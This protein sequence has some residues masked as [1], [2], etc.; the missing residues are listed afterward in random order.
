M[1]NMAE[2]VLIRHGQTTWSKA[3][4]HTSVTDLPL[5]ES[6]EKQ[7]ASLAPLLVGRTFALVLTSPRIRA[8]RTATVAGLSGAEI[9]EDLV[10]WNYG[11]YEGITTQEIHDKDPDWDLWR[12]GCPGGES[13]EQVGARLDRVLD[14]ARTALTHG[15]VALVGHG[16]ALRAATARWLGLAPSA[17]ALFLLDTATLSSL[18]FERE[19]EVLTG[20]NETVK[21]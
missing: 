16:H 10:E 3:G 19:Q 17:G 5:T 11:A 8:T 9:D 12:D 7:A 20:W 13:P 4:R 6:G 2:I 21:G 14:R 18:G 1:A 15:D